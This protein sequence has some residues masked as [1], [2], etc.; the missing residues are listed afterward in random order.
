MQ[1]NNFE[2]IIHVFLRQ[3]FTFPIFNRFVSMFIHIIHVMNQNQA[4]LVGQIGLRS[5]HAKVPMG[6]DGAPTHC[7]CFFASSKRIPCIPGRGFLE[8]F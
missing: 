2:L 6:L 4:R 3:F 7:M 1:T 5:S 8:C